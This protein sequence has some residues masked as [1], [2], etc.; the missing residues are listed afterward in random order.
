MESFLRTIERLLEDTQERLVY[1]L[2]IYIQTN[3]IGYIPSAGDL[4]YPEKLEM[5]KVLNLFLLIHKKFIICLFQ[6]IAQN[7]MDS[8]E[9]DSS[10]ERVR[11]RSDSVS[12]SLSDISFATNDKSYEKANKHMR[13]ES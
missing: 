9:E 10:E 5:M 12:S 3:I 11:M 6:S 4:A 8:K 7:L 1:R 13:S 2:N